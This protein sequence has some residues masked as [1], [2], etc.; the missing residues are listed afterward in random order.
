MKLNEEGSTMI[1]VLLVILVFTVLGLALMGNV[2]N[3]SVRVSTTES[4]M[5]ARNLAKNGLTYFEYDLKK[6]IKENNPSSLNLGSFFNNYRDWVMIGDP[7]SESKPE[8]VKIKAELLT[9]LNGKDRILLMDGNKQV[10]KVKGYLVKVYSQGTDNTSKKTVTGYY[11]LTYDLDIDTKTEALADFSNAT[12]INFSK[13]N[14]LGLGLL[15]DLLNLS[16]LQVPGSSSQYYEVPDSNILSANLLGIPLLKLGTGDFSKMEDHQVIATREG[17][18]LGASLINDNVT[19]DLLNYKDEA[20]TNVII[21]GKYTNYLLGIPISTD[22]KDID[23]K[24]FAIMGNGLIIPQGAGERKFTFREGLYV[25]KSLGIGG[26]YGR[27]L[28]GG[29]MAVQKDAVIENVNLKVRDLNIYAHGNASIENACIQPE[30]NSGKF[31][32]FAKGKLTIY[33]KDGCNTLKGLFYAKEGIEIITNGKPLS[34][35]G[36]IIGNLK[37]DVPEKLT[38]KQNP[39]SAKNEMITNIKLTQIGQM[40]RE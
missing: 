29:D 33:V 4:T 36:G 32:L 9:E 30:T 38:I 25:N 16:L 6:Y 34:I 37:V 5:Q 27:L 12:A 40:F 8:E 24:K 21:N 20:D 14:V 1:L 19:L 7:W 23:F 22:Y 2:A 10:D 18:L 13:S 28:L 3:E 35:D 26:N 15:S 39:D 31:G 11:A 17:N